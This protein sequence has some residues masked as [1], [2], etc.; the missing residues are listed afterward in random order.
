[1]LIISARLHGFGQEILFR[2]NNE[3]VTS[4]FR[5]LRDRS[6]YSV[7]QYG[8]HLGFLVL[9]KVL[10]SLLMIWMNSLCPQT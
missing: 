5:F 2:L 9:R 8:G 1:M 10:I 3:I 6:A 4:Y 7:N